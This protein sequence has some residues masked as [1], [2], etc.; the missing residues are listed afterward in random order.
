MYTFM[1]VFYKTNLL[2]SFHIFKLNDL[3]GIRDL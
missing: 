1:E 3:K 2:M